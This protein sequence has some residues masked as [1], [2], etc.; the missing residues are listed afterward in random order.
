MPTMARLVCSSLVHLKPEPYPSFPEHNIYK[1][2]H[3]LEV[4]ST[5]GNG[6]YC[7]MGI[8][9]IEVTSY[10]WAGTYVQRHPVVWK[11]LPLLVPSYPLPQLP[12]C[13]LTHVSWNSSP[14][15]S[16]L[17]RSSTLSSRLSSR[18]ICRFAVHGPGLVNPKPY[19]LNPKP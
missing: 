9:E 8:W 16:R 15:P 12:S 13:Y 11:R 1:R 14:G 4:R 10:T 18:F 6:P 7:I 19:T 3:A 5:G 17:I 2:G